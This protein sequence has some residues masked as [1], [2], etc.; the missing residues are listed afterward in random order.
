MK[1]LASDLE[2]LIAKLPAPNTPAT[3]PART[4]ASRNIRD[5]RADELAAMIADYQG[6]ATLSELATEHGYNRVG[7][8]D[9][10]KR[11]GVQLRKQGLSREQI[12]QAVSLH[13]SGM[14]LARIGARFD[15]N[16]ATV[17]TRLLERRVSLRPASQRGVN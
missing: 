2:R 10:L 4:P 16:A 15:V 9:A 3:R 11:A 8:S 1:T 7:I 12:D 5:L 14:S 6:G 13:Q 17:R